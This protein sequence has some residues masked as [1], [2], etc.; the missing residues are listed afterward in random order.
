VRNPLLGLS[1]EI[2]KIAKSIVRIESYL[3]RID[4]SSNEA[5]LKWAKECTLSIEELNCSIE[6]IE[7]MRGS[8]K[9]D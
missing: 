9:G 1:L 2:R 3:T 5:I 7:N 6:K 4:S 8:N